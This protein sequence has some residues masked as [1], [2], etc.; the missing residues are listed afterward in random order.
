MDQIDKVE[1]NS[2]WDSFSEKK[3]RERPKA[4]KDGMY[5]YLFVYG[6]EESTP[7]AIC[8]V[9]S[10]LLDT[11]DISFA[12]NFMKI[13]N[14]DIRR[15]PSCHKNHELWQV[16][17][18]TQFQRAIARLSWFNPLHV[19]KWIRAFESAQFYTYEGRRVSLYVLMSGNIS[20]VKK[21]LGIKYIAFRS[22]KD[23][24]E[25]IH[26]EKWIRSVIEGKRAMLLGNG[27]S[28]TILGLAVVPFP[29]E[30]VEK[31]DYA[32]HY[33]L[34]GLQGLMGSRD[35]LLAANGD[36]DTVIMLGNESCFQRIQ[37]K[38]HYRNYT[39]LEKIVAQSAADMS[40]HVRRE[41]LRSILDLSYEK[42]GAIFLIANS[43]NKIGAVVSDHNER[44]KVNHLLRGALRGLSLSEWDQRSIILSAAGTDGATL[45]TKAGKIID[46]ACMIE[47]PTISL[48]SAYGFDRPR[49]FSGARTTAAWNAS[50]HGLTI[51]VSSDGPIEI[52][53]YGKCIYAC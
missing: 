42:K 20:E 28:G 6:D 40:V 8:R 4:M 41:L 12:Q 37:G 24:Q 32:P 45:L 5:L 26:G 43:K 34:V 27:K 36:S 31:Q 39:H 18:Q 50:F 48:L 44:N 49:K 9:D 15:A 14:E 13:F 51:K 53:Q 19:S 35:L 29:G 38:W 25:V 23:F 52:Y 17:R 1:V 22:S 47:T 16:L 46:I 30:F 3:K 11:V 10:G 33:S 21:R 7:A 2:I